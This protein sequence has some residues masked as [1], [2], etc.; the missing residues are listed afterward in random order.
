MYSSNK[1]FSC[2]SWNRGDQFFSLNSS[3]TGIFYA[4]QCLN[5]H[6]SSY[7]VDPLQQQA[8]TWGGTQPGENGSGFGGGCANIC[9]VVSLWGVPAGGR[10]L[11][12]GQ[13]WANLGAHLGDPPFPHT[14]SGLPYPGPLRKLEPWASL[15]QWSPGNTGTINTLEIRSGV[16]KGEASQQLVARQ[17]LV[18]GDWGGSLIPPSSGSFTSPSPVS[19]V[20]S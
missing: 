11:G 20:L 16:G 7:P 9:K 17:G 8:L 1:C 6:L 15:M 4:S 3:D 18:S 13:A 2:L 10:R 5:T 14:Q 12:W 19:S